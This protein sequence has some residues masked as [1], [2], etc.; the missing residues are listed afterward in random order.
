MTVDTP[1]LGLREGPLEEKSL[2]GGQRGGMRRGLTPD[3]K[4]STGIGW[5]GKVLDQFEEL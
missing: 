4:H 2:K 1:G 3:R 5:G